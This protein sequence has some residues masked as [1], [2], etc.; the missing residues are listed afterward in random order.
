[1]Q[2]VQSVTLPNGIFIN[3]AVHKISEVNIK[4]TGAM[5]YTV[6]IHSSVDMPSV[7][8]EIYEI[9]Y[10]GG[11]VFDVAIEDYKKKLIH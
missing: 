9:R 11:N 8:S 3:S 2:L 6:T 5:F 7:H 1:M 4:V 10:N